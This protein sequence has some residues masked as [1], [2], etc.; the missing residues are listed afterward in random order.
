MYGRLRYSLRNI[1]QNRYFAQFSAVI[2]TQNQRHSRFGIMLRSGYLS[3]PYIHFNETEIF[4]LLMFELKEFKFS[5]VT[6][7]FCPV[8]PLREDTEKPQ[9]HIS[10]LKPDPLR[11]ATHNIFV[12]GSILVF[13]SKKYS[14]DPVLSNVIAQI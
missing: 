7:A 14:P 1:D 3:R 8:K 12:S 13:F 5:L 10:C 9:K 4:F 11:W 6:N 2:L